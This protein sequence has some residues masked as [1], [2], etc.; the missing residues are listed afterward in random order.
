MLICGII[1]GVKTYQ[2]LLCAFAI[3]AAFADGQPFDRYQTIIDRKPFGPEPANFDPNAAPGSASSE[4]AADSEEMTA[5]QRTVEEQKL[6]SNVRISILN[7]APDGTVKVGFT[8]SSAKPAENYYLKVGGSQNGWTVKSADPATESVTL[9][10]GG[11]AVTMKLGEGTGG[12]GETRNAPKRGLLRHGFASGGNVA[13]KGAEA[14]AMGGLARLRQQRM[15]MEAKQ[16]EDAERKRMADAAAKAEQAAREA[17]AAAERQRAEEEREQ[18]R[19]ALFQIQE[20]LK[21]V[22]EEREEREA[23]R[24]AEQ[25]TPE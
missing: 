16:R 14:P 4:G 13:A 17:D 12:K 5:E 18:Q 25:E 7:V 19:E 2:T 3:F 1:W 21:K 9:E 20:Q 10:K 23:A 22:R 11:V 6:A 24:K 15:E 8:D